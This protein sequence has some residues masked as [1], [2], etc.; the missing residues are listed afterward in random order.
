MKGAKKTK[1]CAIQFP[2][3]SSLREDWRTCLHRHFDWIPGDHNPTDAN[4]EW[5]ENYI[6][7]A[8]D[9]INSEKYSLD[10]L[11]VCDIE[12]IRLI[13]KGFLLVKGNSHD[14]K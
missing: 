2:S 1:I 3:D 5:L 8:I 4:R 7:A 9:L 10:E 13:V 14:C 11:L 12:Q 6:L